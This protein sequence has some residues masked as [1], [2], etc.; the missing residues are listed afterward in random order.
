M[1]KKMNIRIRVLSVLAAI[2]ILAGVI[3]GSDM[4]SVLA[5]TSLFS[6]S[7]TSSSLSGWKDA[8]VGSVNSGKYYL[9]GQEAN[10]ITGISDRLNLKISAD[11]TVNVGANADGIIQNSVASLVA[12]ADK[13]LQNGYE[14]GIG[15]TK[16]GTTYAR[17]YLRG[18]ND[19]S[20]IL[21]QKTKD[22]AGTA[23]GTIVAG[24]EYKLSMGIYGGLIQCFIND[25]LAISFEDSTYTSGYC[26]IKTAWSTSVFD[27][28]S[29]EKIEDKKVSS[30]KI[31]NAP[32]QMSLLGELTFDAVITYEGSYHQPETLSA[33][34]SRLAVSGF[35]RSVGVKQVVVSYGG[36]AASFQV[37]VVAQKGDTLVF[38]DK[39]DSLNE[40]NWGLYQTEKT[41]YNVTYGFT[42]N[43]GQLKAT[44][45]TLP[46]GFNSALIAKATLKSEAVE[47]LELYYAT[48][49]AI[50]YNDIATSTVRR[51]TVELS[52]FTD[53]Y[54]HYYSLRVNSQGKI[55]LYY[56][57]TRLFSKTISTISGVKF[58]LGK[59]FNLT[60][61]VSD[62]ILICK[63]NGV[64]VFYYT[65]AYM[66]DYTPKVY[67]RANNGDVAFDNLKVYSM[68]RYATDAVKSMKVMTV[69][70]NEATTYYRGRSLDESK[71]YLLV[72]YI[73]G[74]TRTVGITKDMLSNYNPDLK[75]NQNVVFTYGKAQ[76]SFQFIYSEYLFYED[77]EGAKNP[78]W[79][80]S[81]VE[82]LSLNVQN[83]G[84]KTTWT[85][86]TTN[87][88]A[89][90]A[91]NG[92]E[93]WENY[94]VSMDV[95][96]D[97]DMSKH[98]KSS[99]FY[100]LV[101]R[102]TGNTYYDFRFITRAG[103][104]TMSLYMY[105]DGTNTQVMNFSNSFLKNKIGGEKGL[106]NGPIYN[107]KALCKD[108]TIYM[109]LDDVLI[110]KYTNA[111]EEAPRKGTVG[112]KSSRVS[113]TVD[114][115]I[116][117]EKGSRKIVSIGVEGLENNV[118][119]IYEG[120]EIEAYD[121]T[122]NCHDADGTIFPEVLT[123]DM[124]SP[125]D[126][127]EV[128]VQNITISAYGLK[129]NAQ[130]VVKERNDFINEL[131]KDLESLKI[132]KLTLDDVEKVKEMLGRYDELSAYEIT[133]L[134]KKAVKRAA[135]ARE[136]IELLQY[137]ELKDY[138][139]LYS[140]TFTEEEDCN[141]DVWG[142]GY[143]TSRGEWLFSNGTY[144]L[145]QKRY[146][147]STTAFRMQKYVYGEI[148]SV[149]SRIMLLSENMYAG[150]S[151]NYSRSGHYTTRVKMD[152]YDEEG[153]L[154][155][156]LQVLK[157]DTR[158]FS[159]AMSGYGV[160]VA[161]NEWF[162][163][164]LTCI[165]GVVSAYLN[166]TLV[167]SFD[168]S[169]SV[170]AHTEG[171]AAATINNG[172]G[173]FDN[174]VVRGVAKEIP[175]SA[176]KPIPTEYKDDFEDETKGQN[177][178]YW[179]EDN[180]SDNWKVYASA[181]N[182]YYAT[183]GN[184]GETNTWL[185]VFEVDPT[186]NIDF[187][188]LSVTNAATVGFYIR[189]APETAY[190]RVG[191]DTASQKWYIQE[192]EA[193]KDSDI[194]TTYSAK[195]YAMDDEW[196][197]IKIAASDRFVT[198][199][200][201][202]EKIFDKVKVSQLGYGRIGAY[203]NGATLCI[204]NVKLE[205]PNGDV[206]QDGVLEYTMN[207]DI[208]GGAFDLE[209]LDGDNIIALGS[210]FGLLSENGGQS[211]K[212]I[213]GTSVNIEE[214]DIDETYAGLTGLAGY[215][216][217]IKLHDNSY[218]YVCKADMVV[219]RSTDYGKTWEDIGR[220]LPE[221]ELTD[222][223]GRANISIHNNS[224]TEFQLED[225]TWRIFLPVGVNTYKNQLTYSSSGHYTR[226]F[227]S[228]D[229][230]VTWQESKD[231]TRDVTINYT[232]GNQSLEWCESKIIKCSDG[233]LRMYLSRAK[234][235]CM[236]Y[237]ISHDNGVT[238]EGQYPMPEMQC[239]QSSF[240]LVHDTA[241]PGTYYLVW[242]NNTP[243]KTGATF[244]RTRLSLARSTDGMNWEFLCDLER[245]SEEIYGN[246]MSNT[247]PLMQ[248]VD[249][250][251]HVDDEYVYVTFARSDGTDPTKITGSS[252]N[253]HNCLRGRMVRIE[254]SKLSAKEWGASNISDMLFVK[255]LEVTKPI[256]VRFGLGDLFSYVGGE[257]EATRLDGTTVT[258]D[259]STLYLKEEPDMFELGKHEVV[260]YNAN[261]TQV[262]YEIEV[263]R[264]Y[265]ITWN[266]SGEGTIEPRDSSVL[267]GDTLTAKISANSFFEKAVVTVND[268]KVR[269][270][271]GKLVRKD[272]MEDLEITVNFVKKGILDY[273]LYIVILLIIV[274]VGIVAGI[275]IKKK[276]GPLEFLRQV[277]DKFRKREENGTE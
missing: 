149:S 235:G 220:V 108:D 249:P 174:F 74:S 193:E 26:G 184:Q 116:V 33:D 245:M 218:I 97:Q 256:K 185:H 79:N 173:K 137:P 88:A 49:D 5:G 176:V 105:V 268:E 65:G 60:M 109:Y 35:S 73:D 75:A 211:F 242:V 223:M 82:N 267:E 166:D 250:G 237:S 195:A 44:V 252:T 231:D 58:E 216:S 189:C 261:G 102:R 179:L 96:F 233:T 255:S 29:V 162:D 226:V 198:V 141:A 45:P 246:D 21:V 3:F 266:V 158:L 172:N 54:G 113:G 12:G 161:E 66:K 56:D 156:M 200:V 240:S 263:V 138:E 243:V 139:I 134:S 42:A 221:E 127:L 260:L 155:P 147:I 133:K 92:G 101:L 63:Y 24:T 100:S 275:C 227:Y 210:S 157:D 163:I 230:G 253:Y 117:E 181:D 143:G 124:L 259:T 110:G 209:N 4:L 81:S 169:D 140:N 191:Y 67:V 160:N 254:K 126:N 103:T 52:A 121:Y 132:K 68:E 229:G 90:A 39:F 207:Q 247:S 30:I 114:N 145:E 202:G 236:Q 94:S 178:N 76:V 222:D 91:V 170:G 232:E 205:F 177:P 10:S 85:G 84:L 151:L 269:L 270:T 2:L 122:L 238:W 188:Y 244:S 16:T 201:D 32:A 62:N 125:Y 276:I 120:F 25:K 272:V 165:D 1:F 86:V 106:S 128:G 19:N 154:V 197:N 217:I 17:L 241:N 71:F 87:A 262:S 135:S 115:F 159:K 257:V 111:T 186:V 40:E 53:A 152:Y 38:A 277:K 11:V 175:T 7:F 34:D 144:R 204:D 41:N 168:D 130:V 274:G 123:D 43:G 192:T 6:D 78:L 9:S 13:N 61:C 273:L 36:K 72:T 212:V 70:G 14:F 95:S 93:D 203:T 228:D 23:N 118:F 18:S 80:M 27:N 182:N 183:V 271:N 51:G 20:R 213:G 167:Y 57:S 251:V 258:M 208:Y 112:M 50:I 15:I 99:S 48:V 47:E 148:S 129:V 234:Y 69:S 8:G 64:D 180:V 98:I 196:H 55:E 28:V 194:I 136:K 119:E 239:A 199:T 190:V 225:G 224:F 214:E 131:S 187:K 31:E 89:Y 46:T 164:R 150:V 248:I 83:G 142:K 264:K 22:I 104:L 265:H 219:K 59:Q 215:K 37:E 153:T 146:G 77:F 171:Y 206:P 107:M